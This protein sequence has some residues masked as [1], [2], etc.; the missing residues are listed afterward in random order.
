M[1]TQYLG[2]LCLLL[3]M[4]AFFG[5]WLL[6]IKNRSKTIEMEA[7]ALIQTKAPSGPLKSGVYSLSPSSIKPQSTQAKLMSDDGVTA[8]PAHTTIEQSLDATLD[9]TAAEDSTAKTHFEI[10]NQFFGM[11]DFEG[12]TEMCQ[13]ILDNPDASPA[14]KLSAEQLMLECV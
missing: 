14:Q 9:C 4:A 8:A 11:G 13:L 12:A 6:T 5:L 1:A 3:G 2:L 7:P 10:A